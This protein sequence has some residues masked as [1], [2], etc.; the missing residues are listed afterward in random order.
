MRRLTVQVKSPVSLFQEC[1]CTSVNNFAKCDAVSYAACIV[2]PLAS[3]QPHCHT[4]LREKRYETFVPLVCR[5][6]SVGLSVPS[7]TR[8]GDLFWCF[9]R[10]V[11]STVTLILY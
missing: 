9:V 8:L 7:V 11:I 2:V 3:V 10:N 6:S 1:L 5:H 4:V